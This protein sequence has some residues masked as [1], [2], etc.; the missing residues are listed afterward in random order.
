[1]LYVK[2]EDIKNNPDQNQNVHMNVTTSWNMLIFET[3]YV[4]EIGNTMQNNC[5]VEMFR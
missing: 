3:V 5:K 2:V 4:T 1:M